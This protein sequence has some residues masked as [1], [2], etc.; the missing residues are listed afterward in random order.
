MNRM[1]PQERR[2]R[3]YRRPARAEDR[4]PSSFLAVRF[5][6]DIWMMDVPKK[7]GFKFKTEKMPIAGPLSVTG[8]PRYPSQVKELKDSRVTWH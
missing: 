4:L 5:H 8:Y 1:N 3:K 6:T 7:S 2:Q